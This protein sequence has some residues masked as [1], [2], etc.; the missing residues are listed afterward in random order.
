[1]EIGKSLI[2]HF[3]IADVNCKINAELVFLSFIG[4]WKSQLIF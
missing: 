1:M 2:M 4:C 3:I